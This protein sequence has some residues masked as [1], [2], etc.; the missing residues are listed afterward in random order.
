MFWIFIGLMILI[1][2]IAM[3][4]FVKKNQIE[5]TSTKYE[6]KR[7]LSQVEQIAFIKIKSAI[8][9]EKFLLSQVAFS[10]FIKVTGDKKKAFAKFS[11]ARQKVA[12]FVVCNKDFS[13]H[14]IIEIDD[15][16]HNK[17]KDDARD[18]ITREAGFKTLRYKAKELPSI[19]Q[20]R[21]DLELWTL[22]T[23]LLN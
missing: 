9:E 21:K 18:S 3:Q 2:I 7:P 5:D 16:T 4:S 17:E 23:N 8:D 22:H 15:R 19:E 11:K 12:D 13:I 6:G 14:S 1:V 10:S 20:L